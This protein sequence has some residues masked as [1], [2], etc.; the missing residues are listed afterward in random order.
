M[1]RAFSLAF[2]LLMLSVGVACAEPYTSTKIIP[3]SVDY[4]LVRTKLYPH[5]KEKRPPIDYDFEAAF[6]VR[7]WLGATSHENELVQL[8]LEE[9]REWN[10]IYG[11]YGVLGHGEDVF[12]E[13]AAIFRQQT[14]KK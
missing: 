5:K 9:S 6:G 4:P 7:R 1:K 3:A 14:L 8:T 2:A 11:G 10:K 12:T 13:E